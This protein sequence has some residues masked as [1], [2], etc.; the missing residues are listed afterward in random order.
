MCPG[1][2]LHSAFAA[3]A[4][5]VTGR[6]V[7]H[8]KS[9]TRLFSSRASRSCFHGVSSVEA[10][11]VTSTRPKYIISQHWPWRVCLDQPSTASATALSSFLPTIRENR[12]RTY[13]LSAPLSTAV[14]PPQAPPLRHQRTETG[15]ACL[16]RSIRH[17]VAVPLFYKATFRYRFSL[18]HL[19]TVG[20][21]GVLCHY[22]I[23]FFAS[24]RD[25][26]YQELDSDPSPNPNMRL[27][28]S[29]PFNIPPLVSAASS[30][31]HKGI[32]WM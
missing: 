26:W 23:S 15:L 2:R 5:V 7:S 17:L 25:S 21:E 11:C 13:G 29:S 10:V 1:H 18:H 12:D 16:S 14:I 20:Q 32:R 8:N 24:F 28:M 27:S 30:H 4:Q 6:W 31:H 19:G 22:Q 9:E 3:L